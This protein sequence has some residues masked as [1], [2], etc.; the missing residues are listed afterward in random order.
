MS[1]GDT[2]AMVKDYKNLQGDPT[3]EALPRLRRRHQH[4]WSPC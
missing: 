4:A 1:A 2:V 3:H